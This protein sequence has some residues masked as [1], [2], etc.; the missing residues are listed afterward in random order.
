M[1]IVVLKSDQLLELHHN[2]SKVK[3]YRIC[4][5]LNPLGPKIKTGDRRTPEGEY[6]ICMKNRASQFHLFMGLSYPS[7][8]DAQ[9]AFDNG[10]ISLDTRN[11]IIE[12]IRRGEAPPWNTKLGGWVGIHGYPSA[13]NDRRWISLLYPKPHNWTDGCIAL[14]NFE[15]EELFS[16]VPL[17]TPVTIL[18]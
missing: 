14:W 3:T 12:K 9:V 1:R 6:F 10:L 5:G 16:Q 15:I 11:S 2:G 17:G 8:H 4:L 13:E 7:E 18:P